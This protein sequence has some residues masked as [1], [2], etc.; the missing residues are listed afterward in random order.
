MTQAPNMAGSFELRGIVMLKERRQSDVLL[1]FI[2]LILVISEWQEMAVT[3][4][5]RARF[6]TFECKWRSWQRALG[7]GLESDSA[8]LRG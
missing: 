1:T 7:V 2:S 4:P 3:C 6:P 5:S 8:R